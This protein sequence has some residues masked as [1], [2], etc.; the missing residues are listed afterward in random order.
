M[1]E[2]QMLVMMKK[3]CERCKNNKLCKERGVLGILITCPI[4][5]GF[6]E[7]IYKKAQEEKS[8]DKE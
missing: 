5:Y 3:Y 7:D 1:R 2:Y 4:F 6:F 8:C